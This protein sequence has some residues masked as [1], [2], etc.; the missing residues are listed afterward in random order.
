MFAHN[1]SVG[2]WSTF[3]LPRHAF[4]VS[5]IRTK[6]L[7]SNTIS[8]YLHRRASGVGL[9]LL[10]NHVMRDLV[11]LMFGARVSFRFDCS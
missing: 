9:E 8:S 4:G 3:E 7:D 10:L 6:L 11:P 2:Q 5:V 1:L